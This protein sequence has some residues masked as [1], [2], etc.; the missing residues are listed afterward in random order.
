MQRTKL[1]PKT[2]AEREI[3]L[4]VRSFLLVATDEQLWGELRLS[5]QR[6]DHWRAEC[7]LEVLQDNED[8]KP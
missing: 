4:H 1:E 3:R 6:K 7:V 8:Q 2:A 5:V